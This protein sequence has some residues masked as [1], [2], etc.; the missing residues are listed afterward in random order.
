M[1]I[2]VG[3]SPISEIRCNR[4]TQN[5]RAIMENALDKRRS[6]VDRPDSK[7][8]I[9]PFP[10]AARILNIILRDTERKRGRGK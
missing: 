2:A 8:I 1:R 6:P 4:L 5:V 9:F 10:D 3:D 7:Q